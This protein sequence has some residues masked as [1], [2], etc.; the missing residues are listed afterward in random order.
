MTKK[1]QNG[2]TPTSCS[3]FTLAMEPL[4]KTKVISCLI[5]K[6]KFENWLMKCCGI[7]TTIMGSLQKSIENTHWYN[8]STML[9]LNFLS[10]IQ[11]VYPVN[12]KDIDKNVSYFL[13]NVFNYPPNLLLTWSSSQFLTAFCWQGAFW[14]ILES[15]PAMH[16]TCFHRNHQ[17]Q[18]FQMTCHSREFLP[19]CYLSSYACWTLNLKSFIFAQ[20]RLQ[21][22]H[23]SWTHLQIVWAT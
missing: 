10:R 1:L 21:N 20:I 23:Q 5:S 7:H 3:M 12:L 11:T 4:N 2:F 8:L 13:W 14:E 17:T 16:I 6:N 18:I 9:M 22:E 15:V 19:V